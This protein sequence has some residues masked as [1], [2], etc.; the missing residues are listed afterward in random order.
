MTDILVDTSSWINFF[1]RREIKQAE[2]IEGLLESG[3]IAINGL[4][5]AELLQ[6]VQRD[7]ER[8]SLEKRLRPIRTLPIRDDDFLRA[9]HL[10]AL[11]RKR[12]ET[13]NLVDILIAQ[14]A[15]AQDLPLLHYDRDFNRIAQRSSLKCHKASLK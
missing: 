12:G 8:N 6:G 3:T 14:T 13:V 9:G 4:I 1:C 5:L 15:I 2:V 11:L 7:E 10:S